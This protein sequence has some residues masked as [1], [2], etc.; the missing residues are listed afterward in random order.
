[1][2]QQIDDSNTNNSSSAAVAPTLKCIPPPRSI[3]LSGFDPEVWETDINDHI[4][5]N[6][7]LDDTIT[8]KVKKM[9]FKEP[10]PYASFVIDVGRDA[11]LFNLLCIPMFWP[12]FAIVREYEFFPKRRARFQIPPKF[13]IHQS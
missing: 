1:M 11:E 8:W 13:H 4:R 9:N 5:G 3:Y 10:K 12:E 2:L 7:D 6:L